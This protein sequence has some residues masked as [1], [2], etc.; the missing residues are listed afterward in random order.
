MGRTDLLQHSIELTSTKPVRQAL[1][2]H[3]VAYLP[4][5]DQYVGEMVEH[6]IVQ[7][8]PGSEWV[9]NIIIIIIKNIVLVRKKDGNLRYCVDHRGLNTITQKRNYP[10][11]HL[12][13]I[14]WQQLPIYEPGHVQWLLAGSGEA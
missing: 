5:I 1:R 3:P 6:G 2:R 12:L 7:P 8:M 9:A 4:L 10:L 11:R 14:T 13:G